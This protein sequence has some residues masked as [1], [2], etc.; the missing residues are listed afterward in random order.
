[1]FHVV[2]GFQGLH[3]PAK[4]VQLFSK[5]KDNVRV[6]LEVSTILRVMGDRSRGEDPEN[7]YN[8]VHL[9]TPRGLESQMKE[10]HSEAFHSLIGT[11]NHTEVYGLMQYAERYVSALTPPPIEEVK[12]SAEDETLLNGRFCLFGIEQLSNQTSS[13]T[14]IVL[15]QLASE[16]SLQGFEILKIIVQNVSLPKDIVKQ[17][18]RKTLSIAQNV[19]R[20]MQQKY[21]MLIHLQN[22]QLETLKESIE[23]K[24]IELIKNGEL[25]VLKESF[26]L[27]FEKLC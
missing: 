21:D 13:T 25:D 14:S 2:H 10:A 19:E 18:S 26:E 16:F 20:Q 6:D 1:M 12:D 17:M 9:V 7:V 5:T 15:E 24:K 11:M 4:I 27:E 22:E 23:E 3:K 8:F